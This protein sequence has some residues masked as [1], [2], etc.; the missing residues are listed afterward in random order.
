MIVRGSIV[1]TLEGKYEHG[2][3]KRFPKGSFRYFVEV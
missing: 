2:E 1:L 3:S